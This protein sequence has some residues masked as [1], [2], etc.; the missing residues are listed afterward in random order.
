[1]WGDDWEESVTG[2]SRALRRLRVNE[3][4]MNSASML[5]IQCTL[6]NPEGRHLV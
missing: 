3:V 6:C 5:K 4:R 1:M 2:L